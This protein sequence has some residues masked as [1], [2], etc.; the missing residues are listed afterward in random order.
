MVQY[1]LGD[2]RKS[3]LKPPLTALLVAHAT[4]QAEHDLDDSQV[5]EYSKTGVALSD[6]ELLPTSKPALLPA[7]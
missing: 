7:L 1:D 6:K 5:P 2:E 3:I 4:L